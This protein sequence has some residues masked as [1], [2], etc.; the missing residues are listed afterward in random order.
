[1]TEEQYKLENM[2]EEQLNNLADMIKQ[3]QE[4]LG[5]PRYLAK[6]RLFD[7]ILKTIIVAGVI[8]LVLSVGYL[9]IK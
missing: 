3:N 2:T 5:Q 6:L 9:V 4:A 8:G 7:H 1:M